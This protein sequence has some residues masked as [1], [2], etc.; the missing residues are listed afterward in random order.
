MKNNDF[1]PDD[2]DINIGYKELY[3]NLKE[4]GYSGASKIAKC[5]EL[6]TGVLIKLK[7]L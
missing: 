3:L 6:M 1:I 2:V 4:Q 7:V 5:S